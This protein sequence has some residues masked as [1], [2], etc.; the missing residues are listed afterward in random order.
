MF[1]WD[2]GRSC[3]D[4]GCDIHIGP[5]PV[6]DAEFSTDGGLDNDDAR[7]DFDRPSG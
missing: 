4:I 6:A 5:G 2:S 1:E 3:T 7:D